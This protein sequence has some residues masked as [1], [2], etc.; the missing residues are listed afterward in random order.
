[1]GTT[2]R[3]EP[4]EGELPPPKGRVWGYNVHMSTIPP[5]PP[6][7]GPEA[8]APEPETGRAR[9]WAVIAVL[10]LLVLMAACGG[11]AYVLLQPETPTARIRDIV[12]IFLAVEGLLIGLALT[13]LLV[14]LAVLIN[15]LQHEVRPILQET[16][17]TV[18]TLKGTAQFLSRHAAEP[19]IKANQFLAMARGVAALFRRRKP[20]A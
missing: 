9:R 18:H 16:Q 20:R 4:E 15:L 6:S 14:Q 2:R 1:M 12:I 13:V 3:A 11:S 10:V 19:V 17:E 5:S 7:H 8:Q